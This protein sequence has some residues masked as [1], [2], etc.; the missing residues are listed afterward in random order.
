[1]PPFKEHSFEISSRIILD[2]GQNILANSLIKGHLKLV[3]IVVLLHSSLLSKKFKLRK[4]ISEPQRV[5]TF[6]LRLNL[7][8]V[9]FKN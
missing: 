5:N 1:M 8:K 7:Q 9:G 4:P 2:P 6:L 3:G